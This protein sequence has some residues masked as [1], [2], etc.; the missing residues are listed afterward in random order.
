M[1]LKSGCT[2]VDGFLMAGKRDVY[3]EAT[4]EPDQYALI[5]EIDWKI[6]TSEK[7]FSLTSYG[8]E[9]LDF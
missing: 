8:S 4:L 3:V 6:L 7:V 5:V 2:Y 9:D 1:K